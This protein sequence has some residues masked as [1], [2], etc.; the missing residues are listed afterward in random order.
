MQTQVGI[1]GGGP[2][3]LCLARLLS[4]AG[5]KSVILERHDRAH[6]EARIRAGI[7]EQGMV[8]LMRKAQVGARMDREGLLHDGIV[9]SFD[10]RVERVDLSGLTGGKQVMVYGQTELT[11][12]L[13]DAV[14]KDANVRVVFEASDVRPLGFLEGAPVLF[15]CE[16]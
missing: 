8:D 5:I 10:D 2:S 1:I 13:Y 14:L 3:G 16:D 4:L 11:R 15:V 12:D 9:L 7:L 6:V